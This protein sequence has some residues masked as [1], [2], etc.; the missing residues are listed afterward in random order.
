[1]R[2]S[3][4][5]YGKIMEP[6][7]VLLEKVYE[8]VGSRTKRAARRY[9]LSSSWGSGHDN[10]FENMKQLIVASTEISFTDRNENLCLYTDASEHH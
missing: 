8:L 3:I 4:P 2:T 6:L 9:S 5:S 1:M 7:H 10:S